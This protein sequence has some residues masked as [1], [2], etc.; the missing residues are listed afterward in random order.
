MISHII[1]FLVCLIGLVEAIL[2]ALVDWEDL[3]ISVRK[4]PRKIYNVLKEE[5]NLPKD[6]N[7]LSVIER[8]SRK[9]RYNI[10][11]ET[12]TDLPPWDE[13]SVLDR[14]SHKDLYKITKSIYESVPVQAVI[15]E[16][17][18]S[19]DL[20]YYDNPIY[21]KNTQNAEKT[22]S[23]ENGALFL[24]ASTGTINGL[25]PIKPLNGMMNDLEIELNRSEVSDGIGFG[26]YN[27]ESDY[28]YIQVYKLMSTDVK[29]SVSYT[30]YDVE[31]AKCDSQ[32]YGFK[33]D[34]GDFIKFT[35]QDNRLILNDTE[36]FIEFERT[37]S[38]IYG[39]S[40]NNR[41]NGYDSVKISTI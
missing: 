37:D 1:V 36:A 7:E 38:T 24:P 11:R 6:W 41:N 34:E 26:Y 10:I 9:R 8:R 22:V 2:M 23:F 28:A 30:I 20:G 3:A 15:L 13:L 19:E 29:W 27:N 21:L 31:K 32:L 18:C 4:S 17:D 14:R 33:L 12:V 5:L 16:D 40:L 39:L 35:I 25:L